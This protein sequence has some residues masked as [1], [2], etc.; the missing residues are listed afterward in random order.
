MIRP[1]RRY[2]LNDL[3]RLL[4]LHVSVVGGHLAAGDEYESAIQPLIEQY[5]VKCH[6]GE[7][8]KGEVDFTLI[9]SEA[10]LDS[11]FE[12]WE[13]VADV[14]AYDE[15][16]PEEADERPS[17]DE[18]QQIVDWY[19][20]RFVKSVKPRPGDFKP[21]RLSAPEYRNTL[22]SILGFDLEVA[23]IEAEQTTMESSLALKLLPTDP[24]GA[25]GYINDTYAARLSSAIWEQYA[26]LADRGL[27]ELF[28]GNRMQE[29]ESLVGV[30]FPTPFKIADFNASQAKTLLQNFS[31]KTYRRPVP[32]KNL[33]TILASIKGLTG[34]PLVEAVKIEMKALLVSPQF[35]YRGLLMESKPG[36]QQRVDNYELAERLSYFLWEDMPDEALLESARRG[37][38]R[39]PDDLEKQIDRMLASP[40]AI[41]LA[42]SFAHQWLGLADIDNADS[43]VTKRDA[44]RSQ[45]L[46]FLNYL[47]TEDRPVMELLDSEVTFTNYITASFY[48]KDKDQLVKYIKPKGIERQLVPNQRIRLVH[49]E[50]RGGILTM[51]GILAMNRGPV[52]RGT[53]MLRNILG[54]RLGEPPADIPAIKAA[55]PDESLTFRQRFEQHRSDLTCARCHDR[56]DPLGFAM[57][58][59]D[60]A[61][62]YKLDPNYKPPRRKTEHD[63]SAEALDASGQLPSGETF[64]D[65]EGLK[66]ILVSTKRQ[67]IIRN[68]VKQVM[69]YALCRKLEAY[70]TPTITEIT[71]KIDETNGSWRDLFIEVALSLPFQETVTPYPQNDS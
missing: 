60:D 42:E 13:T 22:H 62:A 37:R 33:K 58:V 66:A 16:P 69:A 65:F 38:L 30:P 52:L 34:E 5:C 40:K 24:P 55:L 20:D 63:D 31:Q 48:P 51:P 35:L 14:L 41:N 28:S 21:R 61:G 59:Y 26:Y 18:A 43:D 44:L 32:R 53:W 23:F 27:Q 45:P 70:D 9:N 71:E 50:D 68:A 57:Q 29:L 1:L 12:L 19:E 36:Q 47:F 4:I 46:D 7:K 11:H 6:G 49:T 2:T 39:K 64:D 17:T 54:E 67:D 10:D 15:M 3:L 8:V 25:S 56:L